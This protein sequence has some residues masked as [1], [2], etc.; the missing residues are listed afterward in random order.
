[1]EP[2]KKS[3]R[4]VGILILLHLAVGLITPFVIIDR[5]RTPA[6]LLAGAAANPGQLR[7]AV[8]LL[9]IGSAIPIAIAATA[10]PVLRRCSSASPLWLFALAVAGFILQVV[11][12]GALLSTLSLSQEYAKA[13]VAK[14][15]LQAVGLVISAIRRW[16]HFTYLLVAVGWIFLF[17]GTLYRFRFAHRVLALL[18][19]VTSLFQIYGVTLRTMFGYAPEMRLAMPLAPAYAAL[20]M[21]L[22]VN[23]FDAR[24]TV[25]EHQGMA[26]AAHVPA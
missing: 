18:G 8:L 11:D 25:L 17:C 19:V 24:Y 3:G 20:A 4:T 7:V 14:D 16:T 1:M 15:A 21:W 9:F 23:G 22:I 6:G 12:G 10:W 2:E 13:E 26:G 5:I